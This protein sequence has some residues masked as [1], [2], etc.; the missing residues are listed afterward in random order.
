MQTN[1]HSSCREARLGLELSEQVILSQAALD[2]GSSE[3]CVDGAETRSVTSKNNLIQ[4]RP[5]SYSKNKKDEDIVR[6]PVKTG[7]LSKQQSIAS[8]MLATRST[9]RKSSSYELTSCW[10]ASIRPDV[11][12]HA[13][14]NRKVV[15]NQLGE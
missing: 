15:S 5:A 2:S 14:R 6:S 12:I 11:N 3:V 13:S 7:G 10:S 8:A 1:L 9:K 4:E